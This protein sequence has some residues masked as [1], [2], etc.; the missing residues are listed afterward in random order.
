MTT[1]LHRLFRP[2]LSLAVLAVL[3][4]PSPASA[5]QKNAASDSHPAV[6]VVRDYLQSALQRDWAKS[7]SLVDPKSLDRLLADYVMRIKAAPTMDDER[8]MLERVGKTELPEVEK[9]APAEFYTAYHKGMQERFNVS[10][11]TMKAVRNS[12]TLNVLSVAA[13]TPELVHVLVRTTHNNGR[14]QMSNLELISLIKSGGKWLVSLDE[15]LPK[16]TPVDESGSGRP[17]TPP[18]PAPQ[19]PAKG[20]KR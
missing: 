17:A 11:E 4:A 14:T 18:A 8:Q 6:K 19:K 15:Q 10:E 2:A 5:Q 1:I 7:A 12:L 16:V 9:M 20:T 13:E 3:L